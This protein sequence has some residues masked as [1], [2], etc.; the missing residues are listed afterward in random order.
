MIDI[1]SQVY[2]KVA[3]K[4]RELFPNINMQS[5]LTFAPSSFPCCCVEEIDNVVYSRGRDS[6]QIENF[7]ELGYE[8][9]VFSNL[10]NGSKSECR[11]IFKEADKVMS[12]LNFTRISA[13]PMTDNNGTIYR[14]TGRYRAVA[15]TN[16]KLYRR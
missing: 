11:S 5:V 1:E 6:G 8:I 3:V 16:N 7:A 4:L 12:E 14:I 10:A 15:G 9:N 2:T 13:T